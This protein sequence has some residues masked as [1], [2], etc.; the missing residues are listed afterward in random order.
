MRLD[1]RR[2]KPALTEWRLLADFGPAALLAV[3]PVTGRTHQIRVHLA[4][5]S[6]PLVIDPLY[7]G[8][9]PV[10]LSDFKTGYLRKREQP[11]KPLIERLTLHAYQIQMTLREEE[12][13]FT[14]PLDKKFAATIKMLTKH[15]KNGKNAFIDQQDY[16]N[17]IGAIAI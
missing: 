3:N 14:A 17:I 4:S 7:G 12:K 16:K 13:I 6:M 9:R 5:R 1:P 8:T 2:G 15:N 10:L 11:E